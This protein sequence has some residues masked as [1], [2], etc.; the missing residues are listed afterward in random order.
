M[1]ALLLPLG[2]AV[3]AEKETAKVELA[4]TVLEQFMAAERLQLTLEK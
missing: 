3:A 1:I 2:A 4:V